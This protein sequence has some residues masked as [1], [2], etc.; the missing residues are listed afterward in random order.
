MVFTV[1]GFEISEESRAF[2]RLKVV[3]MLDGGELTI[4]LHI[5]HGSEKGPVLGLF[6]CIHGT[7]YYSNRIIKRA[8]EEINV[9]D[10]KGTVLAVPVANPIAFAHGTRQTPEPPEETVDFS[11]LNRVFPGRRL[12]HLFGS[13]EETDV[14]LT[15]RMAQVITNEVVSRCTHIID[16]HGQR[17]GMALNKMLFNRAS[18]EAMTLAKVFGLGVIHDPE[19]E[20][21]GGVIGPMT[22]YAERLGIP[23][24]AP[25]IGGAGH[26]EAFEKECEKIGARGVANTLKYLEMSLGEPDLPK[27]QFWFRKAPHIRATRSGYLVSNMEPED[28][29]IGRNPREVKKGEILATIFNPYS[30][31]E[32]EKIKSPV[33]GL[34]Y[35]CRTSGILGAQAEV[36]AV[37][38][39]DGS[40][41]LE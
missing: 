6:A 20:S 33:D 41:W 25:E 32:V 4:P 18:E 27:R 22:D 34:L 21:I 37:A 39:F 1:Q 2:V 26:S 24:V 28:V 15:M 40:K 14:S 11:N 12:T 31:L 35:A 17:M 8:L 19:G 9:K 29:G 23:G 10:L 36:L 7:E 16:F 30:L 5:L 3:E 38:D 13:K